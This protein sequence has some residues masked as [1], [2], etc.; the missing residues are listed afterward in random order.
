M[1]AISGSPTLLKAITYLIIRS[2][3]VTRCIYLFINF[4]Y[5]LNKYFINQ[6]ICY[7]C[8]FH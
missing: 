2:K 1:K 6:Y 5:F 7:V 4:K 3:D 8:L